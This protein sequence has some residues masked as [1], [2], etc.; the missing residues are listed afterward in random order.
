MVRES[1][2]NPLHRGVPRDFSHAVVCRRSR[3]FVEGASCLIRSSSR[4]RWRACRSG[5]PPVAKTSHERSPVDCP[6]ITSRARGPSGVASSPPSP[7]SAAGWMIEKEGVAAVSTAAPKLCP[8]HIKRLEHHQSASKEG[9]STES[10]RWRRSAW[11]TEPTCMRPGTATASPSHERRSVVLLRAT[12]CSARED[13]RDARRTVAR[14]HALVRFAIQQQDRHSHLAP[15]RRGAV[16]SVAI[17]TSNVSERDVLPSDR[18]T[19]GGVQSRQTWWI[20]DDAGTSAHAITVLITAQLQLTQASR[21]CS[22]A[23]AG[24]AVAFGCMERRPWCGPRSVR[25]GCGVH[26]AGARPSVSVRKSAPRN[27]RPTDDVPDGGSLFIGC[28]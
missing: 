17:T 28:W 19:V 22:D 10:P 5:A 13:A 24:E 27:S 3:S 14:G 23:P 8:A 18:R 4:Y 20:S 25:S 21:S 11:R 6:R 16:E 2:A 12:G 1:R 26:G 9:F 7:T 15:P